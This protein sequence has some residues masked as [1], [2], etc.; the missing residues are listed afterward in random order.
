MARG[1]YWYEPRPV[2]ERRETRAGVDEGMGCGGDEDGEDV[3][4]K[5][6]IYGART[7]ASV[8]INPNTGKIGGWE[9]LFELLEMDNDFLSIDLEDADE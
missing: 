3:V 8:K 9:S 2:R 5:S 6:R 4:A 7:T 1:E